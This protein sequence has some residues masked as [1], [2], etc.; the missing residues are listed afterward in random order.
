MD[1][2]L[3]ID[4]ARLDKGG[5]RFAGELDNA[6]LEMQ[7]EKWIR[8]FAPLRYD[9]F[10]QVFGKELLVRGR[11]EQDFDAVCSR[12]GEDFDFTCKAEEF[13]VSEEV[14]E[15][16]EFFDLTNRVRE[17]IILALPNY[18]VCGEDCKGVCPTC[19]KNLNK[20]ACECGKDDAD[21]RWAA[22]DGFGAKE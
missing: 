18:P 20:G 15:D 2:K 11:L 17:C 1:E 14:G 9:V 10:V 6:V 21:A 7:N 4:L 13:E 5:E 19:G 12:C 3:E 16:V 22:L 8:P